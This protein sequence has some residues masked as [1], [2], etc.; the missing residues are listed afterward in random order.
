[1]SRDLGTA[2]GLIDEAVAAALAGEGWTLETVIHATCDMLDA[3]KLVADIERAPLWP[4]RSSTPTA[5]PSFGRPIYYGSV[6]TATVGPTPSG[7]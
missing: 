4:T 7:S 1:M 3:C 6:L 2:L 5:A